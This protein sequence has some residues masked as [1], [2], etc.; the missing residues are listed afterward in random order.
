MRLSRRLMTATFLL[1]LCW[2]PVSSLAEPFPAPTEEVI[3]TIDGKLG[4]DTPAGGIALD[5]SGL[6]ALPATSFTT[7][8]IWTDGAKTFTGVSLRRL[9]EMA[10][11][12][13]NTVWA[14]ALNGY[15]VEMNIPELHPEFPIIAYQIDGVE[16]SRRD[17]GPL[18]I[19]YPYDLDERYRSEVSFATSVWQL[20]KMTVE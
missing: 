12:S 9:L 7:R 5:L 13:G 14:E 3:L 19:V 10:G 17:K 18:W 2:Q 6:K 15:Q 11:A 16:F 4:P 20:Q 8:T 1:G